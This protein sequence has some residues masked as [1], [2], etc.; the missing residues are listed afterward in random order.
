MET[1]RLNPVQT[2]DQIVSGIGNSITI[3]HLFISPGHNF[4]DHHGQKAGKSPLVELDQ[5]R[6]SRGIL[7]RILPSCFPAGGFSRQVRL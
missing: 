1:L 7:T 6:P 2:D 5:I 3:P 4:F